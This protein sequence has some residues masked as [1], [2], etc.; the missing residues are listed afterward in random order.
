[1]TIGALGSSLLVTR[2]AGMPA[3]SSMTYAPP[4]AKEHP[5]TPQIFTVTH[6]AT[7][8]CHRPL[9]A[10]RADTTARQVQ[11]QGN[12]QAASPHCREPCAVLGKRRG[13][14]RQTS[15]R[16][17]HLPSCRM[18]GNVRRELKPLGQ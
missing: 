17:E 5:P 1:M 16:Y 7:V 4:K 11:R 2:K 15:Q 6:P 12:K 13:H 8:T 9:L 14:A 18:D 10:A 3:S